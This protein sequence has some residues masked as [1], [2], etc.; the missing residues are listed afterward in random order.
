MIAPTVPP[1]P[2]DAALAPEPV[3]GNYFVAAYPP[4]SAWT[5]AQVPALH[6]ALARPASAERLG[7]YVH[8][9]FC[10][11]KC[12]YCYYLSYIAQPAA[13]VDRYLEC[14]VQEL[15]L[16]AQ[17]PGIRGR[18]PAFVYFGGGTPSALSS[19][20]V[21]TLAEGLQRSLA[22][23][24]V[25]EV[26]FECA[27]RSVR[28]EFLE[29]LR[30]AGVTRLSMGVQSFDDHL[31]KLNGRVHLAGDVLRACELIRQTKFAWLNLD[32]MCGL[33][34]ETDAQWIESVRRAIALAPDGITIYQTEIPHNTQTYRDI[35]SQTGPAA[36]VSW[37][38]KRRRLAE[39]FQELERAGYTIISGY[40]AV[41][42]PQRHRFCYQEYLWR[43]AD[44]L[45]LGVAAFGYFGGVHAQNAVTAESYQT[46]VERGE[47]PVG[48]ALQLSLEDQLVREFIL[49]LKLGRVSLAPLRARF[50]VEP[51]AVFAQPLQDLAAEGWL[52]ASLE[53]VELTRRGLLRVDRLL[54]RFYD[55]K[56]HSLRYT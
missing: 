16:Y 12:D 19:R 17:C 33:L 9:P 18:S 8:V 25:E 34:G 23:N 39:G 2:E 46:A 20:Q 4:F 24:A 37:E 36:P 55:P 56:Y 6:E 41:K 30:D 7:M 52:S 1:L 26:T 40:N 32:L 31:L 10:Q 11:Q 15:A 13:V 47:L 42:D 5:S 35:K 44:M 48:R 14:V 54:P 43:G 27:P 45:G 29:T 51:L 22:W 21:R 38:T 28:S 49:Q 3:A 50:G 53:A